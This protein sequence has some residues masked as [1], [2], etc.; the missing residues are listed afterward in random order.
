MLLVLLLGTAIGFSQSANTRLTLD[1]R[2]V[3]F[4]SVD[5]LVFLQWQPHLTAAQQEALLQSPTLRPLWTDASYQPPLRGW[6]LTLSQPTAFRNAL[7]NHPDLYYLTHALRTP[8]EQLEYPLPSLLVQPNPGAKPLALWQG[9]TIPLR[10]HGRTPNIFRL[11]APIQR[12]EEVL[13]F[14]KNLNQSGQYAFAEPNMVRILP[15][16]NVNDPEFSQQWALRNTGQEDGIPGEDM[17][18]TDAWALS[19]GAGIKVA[20][21]DEGVDIDHPDLQ[22]NMLPG[23]DGWGQTA[24]NA[25]N[26]DAHGTACA[27]IVAAAAN[28]N[29]GL[30]GVAYDSQI[31][32]VRM[33]Y[34]NGNSWVT[35]SAVIADCI[36]WAWRIGGA[37]ILSNSWG[38]GSPSSVITNAI[39]DAVTQGRGGLGAPVFFASGN[40]NNSSVFYPANLN[41]VIA[42]GAMSMCGERKTPESCDGEFWWGANYGSSLDV[43]APGVKIYTTDNAGSAGYRNGDYTPSFNGTSS[44]CPNAA[45]VMALVLAANPNLTEME[46]RF[47]L[48]STCD[49]SGGYTYASSPDHPNGSWSSELGH[50]RVNALRA[51]Q[52]VLNPTNC[53]TFINLSVDPVGQ[54]SATL[55]IDNILG[56]EASFLVEYGPAGFTPGQGQTQTASQTTILL[57]D[58]LPQTRYDVYVRVVCTNGD[59]SNTRATQFVT[60]CQTANL[61]YSQ[62][63]DQWPPECW[64]LTGGSQQVVSTDGDYL[65]AS[66]WTWYFDEAYATTEPIMITDNARVSFRYSHKFSEFFPD[67]RLVLRTRPT[68]S[69]TWDTIAHL[70][71]PTFNT[72]AAENFTPAPDAD[73]TVFEAELARQQFAG[74]EWVFQFVFTSGFGPNLYLDDFLIESESCLPPAAPLLGAGRLTL[75]PSANGTDILITGDLN[76]ADHWTIYAGACGSEPIGQTTSNTFTVAPEATTTYFVRGEGGC[77]TPGPC[78]GITIQVADNSPPVALCK[79]FTLSLNEYGEGTLFLRD[80][81]LGSFD[82]C[83]LS[84]SSLS[85]TQFTCDDLGE[86]EVTLQVGDPSGNQSSCT[87][88]VTVID[89]QP[90]VLLAPAIDIHLSPFDTVT[91]DSLDLLALFLDGCSPVRINIDSLGFTCQDL[92]TQAVPIT[93]IDTF[94]NAATY[95]IDFLVQDTSGL[96]C[97]EELICE[98]FSESYNFSGQQQQNRHIFARETIVSEEVLEPDVAVIY[99]AGNTIQLLPGFR[100]MAGS[101]FLARTRTCQPSAN[102]DTPLL[103]SRIP[104]P[105]TPSDQTVLRLFPNPARTVVQVAIHLPQPEKATLTLYDLQGRPLRYL[106][107]GNQQAPGDH[108]LSIYLGDLPAGIYT[109]RLTTEQQAQTQRLVV[110]R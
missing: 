85:R 35:T 49:K 29:R 89:D 6:F 3:A 36:D 54:T 19:T 24:G 62:S 86:Q 13:A 81:N 33:A 94:G 41:E 20:I 72:P 59:T 28:N 21:L 55:L 37:D 15:R 97:A 23:Y 63:F 87:A 53:Q 7:A 90:P 10:A 40:S 45:G 60:L 106:W 91:M 82:N 4:Q 84:E 88:T 51:V 25:A 17:Q 71:G 77:V 64:D 65:E 14:A 93:A 110:Q 78:S 16:L 31:L 39:R 69:M 1:Q 30:A 109:L 57:D 26:A 18:V 107:S 61:P 103:Q 46:A 68:T 73:F 43:A 38:G 52:A 67:N 99:E 48:E 83:L 76:D 8:D 22:A 105:T 56:D 5:S 100:A 92:G 32:P 58:L 50:G 44:A 74:Q 80:I 101:T 98:D 108:Q 11:D 47:A 102:A 27:G 34:S 79:D 66:F 70:Q 75:C 96:S 2:V 95:T 42:V 12:G 9:Q 104:D